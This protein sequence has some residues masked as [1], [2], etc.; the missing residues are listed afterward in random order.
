MLEIL[1]RV[2]RALMP[3]LENE[4]AWQTLNIT[5]A[6]PFVE[7]LWLSMS[8][9]GKPIR[10]NLHRIH[11]CQPEDVFF[12][13]HSWPSAMRILRGEYEMG[14]GMTDELLPQA[15]PQVSMRVVGQRGFAYEMTDPNVWHYVKPLGMANVLSLMITGEPYPDGDRVLHPSP[16]KAKNGPLTEAQ[17][18]HILALF[19]GFYK[20]RG[21][22]IGQDA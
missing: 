2:E 21:E 18:K 13:P 14:I 15:V 7:R 20:P 11:P 22:Y 1:K 9:D 5:Y 6:R 16:P 8:V 3:M 12:H 10:V 19:K 17:K 4:A